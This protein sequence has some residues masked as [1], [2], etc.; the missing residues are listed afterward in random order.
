[1]TIRSMASRK[2]V[3]F[4]A[5]MAT[6]VTCRFLPLSAGVPLWAELRTS[7]GDAARGAVDALKKIVSVVRK[8]CP[9]AQ[10]IVRADGGFCREEI[11]A[12]C[13]AQSQVYYCLELARNSRLRDLIEEKFARVRGLAI[14]CGGVA[15]GFQKIFVQLLTSL[16]IAACLTLR[17]LLESGL[18]FHSVWRPLFAMLFPLSGH[19]EAHPEWRVGRR[20]MPRPPPGRGRDFPCS[21]PG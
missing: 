4:T 12:W 19:R 13:E 5:I 16:F 18:I 7:D 20:P 6:T 8:R 1:V 2:D 15:R 21:N 14:L 9:K 11:M 10:I 17:F 3:S